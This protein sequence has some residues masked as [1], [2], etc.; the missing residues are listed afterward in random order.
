MTSLAKLLVWPNDLFG[1]MT[2]LARWLSVRLWTNWFWVW[3][4]LQS[5]ELQ[6]SCL[7]RARS[8]L[9]FGKLLSMDSLWNV[10]VTWQNIHRRFIVTNLAYLSHVF[11]FDSLSYI[12]MISTKIPST[13]HIFFLCSGILGGTTVLYILP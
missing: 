12:D 10:Y 3:V 11:Y 8:S 4:Q 5:L 9:T 7:L 2:S 13:L 6:I 1:Q